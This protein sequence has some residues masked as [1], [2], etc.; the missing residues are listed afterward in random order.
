MNNLLANLVQQ[1]ISN[2]A[3]NNGT[4][5]ATQGLSAITNNDQKTGEAIANNILQTYGI[6]K[7]QALEMARKKFGVR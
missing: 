3:I 6:S 7:E 4:P 2:K 1:T 5:L